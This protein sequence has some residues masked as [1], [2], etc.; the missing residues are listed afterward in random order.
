V[1]RFC[2]A[3]EPDRLAHLTGPCAPGTRIS[4][5]KSRFNRSASALSQQPIEERFIWFDLSSSEE[6]LLRNFAMM[7]ASR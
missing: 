3:F 4:W 6:A 2:V 1:R 5:K 7:L